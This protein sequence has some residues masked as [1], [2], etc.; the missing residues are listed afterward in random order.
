MQHETNKVTNNK[1]CTHFMFCCLRRILRRITGWFIES[2][3]ERT[4]QHEIKQHKQEIKHSFLQMCGP[5][6]AS[7]AVT[8]VVSLVSW[9]RLMA[10]G[11]MPARSRY[12]PGPPPPFARIAGKGEWPTRVCLR[13][14]FIYTSVKAFDP[15]IKTASGQ[16]L[17]C[18]RAPRNHVSAEWFCLIR[19]TII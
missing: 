3:T 4:K 13:V 17:Q 8:H 2:T 6:Y 16:M 10:G 12:D 14:E 5:T 19:N 7:L 18:R 11:I 1:T 15:Q 9:S